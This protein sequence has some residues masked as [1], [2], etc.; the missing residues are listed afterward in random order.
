MDGWTE[1]KKD[2]LWKEGVTDGQTDGW[3]E[4][5]LDKWTDKCTNEQTDTQKDRWMDGK[6]NVQRDGQTDEWTGRLFSRQAGKVK[7][8]NEALTCDIIRL[9]DADP[10]VLKLFMAVIYK[11]S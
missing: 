9:V 8:L 7:I 3:M 10:N 5:K 1:G 6:K 11:F 4:R 2:G